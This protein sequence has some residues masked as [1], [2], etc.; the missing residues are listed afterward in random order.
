MSTENQE[1]EKR[2]YEL[3]FILKVED[4]SVISQSLANREFTILNENP[5]EKVRLAYPIKKEDYAYFG[6]FHFEGELAALKNLRADLKLKP[7]VLR[8]LIISPPFIKKPAW[9]KAAPVK[10]PEEIKFTPPAESGLTNEALEKKIKEL[11]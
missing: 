3:A 4:A 9:R 8:Y 2:K 1:V 6:Y 10:L 11:V 5:L 7:E